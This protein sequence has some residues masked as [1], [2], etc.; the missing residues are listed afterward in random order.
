MRSGNT[1]QS[2]N[3][4]W[5]PAFKQALKRPGFLVVL[6]VLFCGAVG[7]NA[8][9]SAM[10]LHFRKEALPLRA[11]EGLSALPLTLGSWVC[12]PVTQTIDADTA[13]ELGT[14]TY[15]FREYVDVSAL[16]PDGNAVATQA[17]ILATDKLSRDDQ[18]RKLNSIRAKNN[19]AVLSLAV[20]YYTG[21]VDTVPHVPDRC[22]V[23]DGFQPTVYKTLTWGLGQYGPGAAREVPVRFIDFEDQTARGQQNRCVTYFF[24]AN[25]TYEE[26]PLTVRRRL[27]DLFAKYGYFAKIE[28]MTLLPA[29]PGAGENDPLKEG[30]RKLAASAMQKFL[31]AA[32]PEVERLLPDPSIF[33]TR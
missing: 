2:L 5:I 9:T 26:D 12:V 17:E 18:Y 11:K 19:N 23:A 31:T 20:T 4:P 13:H 24:H 27:Q 22:Y 8:A 30:D 14:D 3:S 33:K 32:L 15:V 28:V 6:L 25:G 29:R 21:K 7:I 10:K 1:Y 16:G